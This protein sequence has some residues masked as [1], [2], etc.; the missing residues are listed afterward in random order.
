V[1]AGMWREGDG[2]AEREGAIEQERSNQEA[3]VREGRGSKQ[4]LL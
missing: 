1:E 2:S 4:P 3:R